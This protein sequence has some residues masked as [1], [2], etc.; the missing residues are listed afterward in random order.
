[1]ESVEFGQL[2]GA[3]SP[4][5]RR[6]AAASLPAQTNLM[7]AGVG[8]VTARLPNEVTQGQPTFTIL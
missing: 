5:A 2:P 8:T 3:C 4:A 7:Q 6:A 1:M